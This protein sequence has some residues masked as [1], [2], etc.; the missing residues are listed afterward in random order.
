MRASCASLRLLAAGCCFSPFVLRW[1]THPGYIDAVAARVRIGLAQF[2]PEDRHKVVIMFSAHSVPMNVVNKGDPYTKE[3]AST[4]ERVMEALGVGNAHI[5]AWQ[6][7]VGYLPWMGP[8]T[9]NVIKGLGAQGRKYV[10]SCSFVFARAFD[11][12]VSRVVLMDGH[13]VYHHLCDAY[14]HVLTVPIAFTSDH[15]ETLFEIDIEYAEEAH[16]AG[17][18]HFKRCPSLN[19]EPKL[20]SAMADIVKTHLDSETLHSPQYPLKCPA[21]VNPMCRSISNPIKPYDKFV[22]EP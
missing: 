21:C 6:S 11:T 16:A 15:I 18:E 9:S 7:K 10:R 5:L 1:N 8:S 13:H 3:I 17:I 22:P 4:A 12:L 19:D 2:A 14:R 20:F